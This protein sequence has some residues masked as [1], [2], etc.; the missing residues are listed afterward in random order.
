MN[1]KIQKRNLPK[2]IHKNLKFIYE[3]LSLKSRL[4]ELKDA[5]ENDESKILLCIKTLALL[6]TEQTYILEVSDIRIEPKT[7]DDNNFVKGYEK[8]SVD[9]IAQKTASANEIVTHFHH[10]SPHSNKFSVADLYFNCA[11]NALEKGER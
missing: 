4:Q 7:D 6:R 1:P 10:A 3:G 2:P 9:H 5:K 8:V 11:K